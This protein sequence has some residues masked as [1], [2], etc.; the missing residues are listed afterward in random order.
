VNSPSAH[1]RELVAELV[2]AA[3]RHASATASARSAYADGVAAVEHDI[4]TAQDAVSQAADDVTRARRVVADTDLMAASLWDE[5]K[6][7]RGRRGHHLGPIPA[8]ADQSS[9]DA[10]AYLENTAA[11]IQR[12]R[13]GGEPLPPK[14]LPILFLLGAVTGS[15]LAGFAALVFWPVVLLA[16][17][18]GLPVSRSW[19]DHRFGAR[20]NSSAISLVV[21][22]GTLAA[23]VWLIAR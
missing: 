16:P 19:L 15:I 17:V 1:Y 3:H 21:L 11:R 14:A 18:S 13:R 9:L 5:L 10:A 12:A 6:T 20:L 4:A 8:P 7:V 2:A 23:A 22:G